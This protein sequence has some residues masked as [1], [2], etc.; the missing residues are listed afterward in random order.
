[1]TNI[2]KHSVGVIFEVSTEVDLT[3]ATNTALFIR[4]PSNKTTTWPAVVYGDPVNGVLTY[5]TVSGDLNEDGWYYMQS[6]AEFPTGKQLYGTAVKVKVLD[7][8]EVP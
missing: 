7:N 2:Y 1:M 8:Y 5:T 4:K 6:Y 3:T